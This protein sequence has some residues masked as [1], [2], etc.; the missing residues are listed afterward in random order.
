MVGSFQ[1]KDESGIEKDNGVMVNAYRREPLSVESTDEGSIAIFNIPDDFDDNYEE[2]ASDHLEQFASEGINPFM[3]QD[4]WDECDEIAIS[5]IR[6]YVSSLN[7]SVI[8]VGCGSGKFLKRLN[9]DNA[10]GI[11]VSLNYLRQAISSNA[12]LAKG[13]V[14]DTPY[15]DAVFDV[16]VCTDVLEHVLHLD[17]AVSELVRITKNGG[18]LVV[19]VPYKEDLAPYFSED[20][21]YKYSH[22]RNFDEFSLR[23]MFEKIN[24]LRFLEQKFGPYLLQ[25]GYLKF[26]PAFKGSGFIVRAILAPIKLISPRLYKSIST[27]LARPVEI[28]MIFQ[29]VSSER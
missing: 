20:Y 16:V 22:L 8:D 29:K 13:R 15:D 24:N 2:I 25:R 4:F 26:L 9:S 28:T 10:Y 6:K 21:P 27:F 19:R 17:A 23:L 5:F 3:A 1:E 7:F 14:E 12:E 11:D 18:L